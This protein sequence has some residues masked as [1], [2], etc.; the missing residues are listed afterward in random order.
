MDQAAKSV[1]AKLLATENIT[2]V[3]DNVRTAMFDVKNRVLTLPMW[4]DV[5]AY[6]EDHLIGH[7]VGHALYTPLEGWHDAVC[8][9]GAGY[10]SFLNVVEDARIE[11][12]IQRKYPGLRA[13]FIKS[14]RK[15]LADGFFGAD[16]DAINQMG[17][18]DRI[19][20]YFKCGMS[21]GVK[22]TD[23][24]KQWLPRIENAETWEDV[25]SITDDL[26]GFCKEELEQQQEEAKQRAQEL[27]EEEGE[28]QDD[29]EPA[30]GWDEDDSDEELMESEAGESASEQGDDYTDDNSGSPTS[31]DY[32]DGE[33][34]EGEWEG[35]YDSFS[36]QAGGA[37]AE[38]MSNTDKT[39]RDSINNEIYTTHGGKVTNLRVNDYTRNWSDYVIS[40]KD[41]VNEIRNGDL[42]SYKINDRDLE[43]WR[44]E[45]IEA[46]TEIR[47]E[48]IET[49]G[50][51]LYNEWSRVNKKAVNAMV[52][53]FEMKKSAG[54]HRR[55][56]TSKT[57]VI[58]TVKMNNYKF[59]DDIFKK[60]TIVPEGKN[61]GFIMYLDMSGSMYDV[62][63]ETVEQTLLLTHFCRQ[64]NVPFRVYG[65]TNSLSYHGNIVDQRDMNKGTLLV[66][67][68]RLLELFSSDQR[69]PD[70][71]LIAKA[72]LAQF[73]RNVSKKRMIELANNIGDING[74]SFWHCARRFLELDAFRL[75]GTPM[76][77]AI[78]IGTP[79]AIAFRKQHQLDVL[80]TFFLTDGMSH[81]MDA[82]GHQYSPVRSNLYRD[83]YV[84][85]TCPLTNRT[86]RGN[87]KYDYRNVQATDM[88]LAMYKN[89]TGSNVI[90]YR[91]AENSRRHMESDYGSMVGFKDW[92]VMDDLWH[93]YSK[94]GFITMPAVGYDE[95]Y[96][97]RKSSLMIVDSKIDDTL[98]GATKS[99]LRTAFRKSMV[100][101]KKS[102]KM[103]NDLVA[104]VA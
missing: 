68:G 54:E 41:L 8:A 36:D 28:E 9:K 104:K 7:E 16:I 80:N 39:L 81:E 97:I 65:F 5:S 52:K 99:R 33:E 58:D 101:S 92:T 87:K 94:E 34:E 63:Y 6:T 64:I 59:S 11:K 79:L 50:T 62:M 61:H 1:T 84:T 90:G 24:E 30:M 70:M 85:I 49:F 83:G 35:D 60:V 53:E 48:M 10:K 17:L 69:K 67:D 37:P 45:R 77:E 42:I 86:F 29:D 98:Q 95:C 47:L 44:S 102:R 75:G 22:F 73:C 74:R 96:L 26:F 71:I 25:V 14:Y 66:Q 103:L 72:L 31:S 89:A 23:D 57:G 2:V 21:A 20:T 55:S 3:Q 76:D 43:T 32:E 13:P 100:G 4:A 51:A 93:Q 27:A 18:I 15:L 78:A 19:N 12:L 46:E 56:L 38:P 82:V 91:I 88:L 40:H